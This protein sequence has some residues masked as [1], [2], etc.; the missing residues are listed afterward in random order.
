MYRDS[1]AAKTISTLAHEVAMARVPRSFLLAVLAAILSSTPAAIAKRLEIVANGREKD[2]RFTGSDWKQLDDSIESAANRGD[3]A[4][5]PG[6]LT[7][8]DSVRARPSIHGLTGSASLFVFGENHLGFEG[9]AGRMLPEGTLVDGGA[10]TMGEPVVEDGKPFELEVVREGSA[11]TFSING[12]RIQRHD[13]KGRTVHG[14]FV[15]RPHRAS[16]RIWSWTAVGS[17]KSLPEPRKLPMLVNVFSKGADGAHNTCGN[18]PPDQDRDTG[19]IRLPMWLPMTWNLG[20]DHES[21][22]MKRASK[23]PRKVLITVSDD[24]AKTW[25]VAAEIS[26]GSAA[27]SNLTRLAD[28]SVGVLFE[29]D[30][31]SKIS[32]TRFSLDWPEGT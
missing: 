5:A 26:A 30:G 11:L 20:A 28:G 9:R 15:F 29:S 12:Q 23:L 2:I 10:V 18:P 4:V 25:P 8:G 24:D 13:T 7:N 16:M 27:D 22:I 1:G 32:L 17:F 31:Y 14:T 6:A 19:R 21:R 3:G